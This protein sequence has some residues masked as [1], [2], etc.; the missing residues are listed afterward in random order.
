MD[1]LQRSVLGGTSLR[2]TVLH[3]DVVY[4]PEEEISSGPTPASEGRSVEMV[5]T[6]P[7]SL[8]VPDEVF[9]GEIRIHRNEIGDQVADVL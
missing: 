7:G 8:V 9:L 6:R 5:L 1:Q 4:S 2:F 3:P